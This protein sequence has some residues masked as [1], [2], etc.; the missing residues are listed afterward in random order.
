[1]LLQFDGTV[2]INKEL[3]LRLMK[4]MSHYI[5]NLLSARR[6]S[7]LALRIVGIAFDITLLAMIR[8]VLKSMLF[9]N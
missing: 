5:L 2:H 3:E 7:N 8:T 1:M 4:K 6:S 9:V